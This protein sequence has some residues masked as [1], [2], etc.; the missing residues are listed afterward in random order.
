MNL[1][2]MRTTIIHGGKFLIW[3]GIWTM[4]WVGLLIINDFYF[5][6]NEFLFFSFLACLIA[7]WVFSDK[8]LKKKYS[9]KIEI[10]LDYDLWSFFIIKNGIEEEYKLNDIKSYWIAES[11]NGYSSGLAFKLKSNNPKKIYFAIFNKKQSEDQTDTEE[12]LEAFQSMINNFNKTADK[13]KQ[14]IFTKTFAESVYGL[15]FI[16]VLVALLIVAVFLHIIYNKL[17]MLPISLLVGGGGLLRI[18]ALRQ[19][20]IKRRKNI[21]I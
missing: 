11:S 1:K 5:N 9:E 21:T 4:F 16:Y 15:V 14:I 19:R 6:H 10:K 20:D 13:N 3:L 8:I 7:P 2:L 17:G 12:V 18:I